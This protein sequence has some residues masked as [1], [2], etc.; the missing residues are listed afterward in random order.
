MVFNLDR[1]VEEDGVSNASNNHALLDPNEDT[2]LREGATDVGLAGPLG[3][4]LI[5]RLADHEN[6]IVL[7]SW[8]DADGLPRGDAAGFLADP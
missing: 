2:G 3:G 5:E 6:G 1:I 4:P 8:I 7:D